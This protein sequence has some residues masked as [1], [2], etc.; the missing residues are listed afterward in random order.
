MKRVIS[1][2]IFLAVSAGCSGSKPQNQNAATGASSNTAPSATATPA[3][4]TDVAP[5]PARLKMSPMESI[6]DLD[7]QVEAYH[8]G[9]N[10]TAEQTQQNLQL[11][12][13]IIR[14]TFDIQELSRLSLDKHWDKLTD[15]QKAYFVDLMTRLLE[16]KAIFSKE[17]LHGD[18]KYYQINYT[19]E[20]IQKTEPPIATVSS[21]MIVTKRK[22]DLDLTYKLVKKDSGWKIFDVIVDDAS[23]LSNYKFQFDRIIQKS[24]FDD[25]IKRMEQKLTHIGGSDE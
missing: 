14:G 23:L 17:Q 3:P 10:L 22:M 21:R 7:K 12:K 20:E 5:D 19:K 4:E 24:G 9:Q 1:L 25:L 6:K 16:K 11:K 18:N 15:A 8:L 13:N 2:V